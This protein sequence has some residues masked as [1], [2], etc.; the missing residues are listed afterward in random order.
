MPEIMIFKA[1]KYPQGDFDKERMQKMVDAYDPE[2]N[3]EAPVVIGH[4]FF[5][6]SNESQFAHGWVKS[7]RMDGAGKIY[8]DIPEFSVEVK[9][10]IAE[11]KL[12]YI[13]AEIFEFDKIKAGLSPYLRAVA[14][15]GRDT[16]AVP[17]ARL[18]ALFSFIT[19]RDILI[20]EEE[21]TATF[22]RRLGKGEIGKE[23]EEGDMGRVEELEAALKEKEAQIAAFQKEQ[24]KLKNAGRKQE[25]EAYFGKLRDEGKLPPALFERA[26]NLD[27]RLDEESRT[28]FRALVGE[29]GAKVDLSGTHQAKKPQ[30]PS[31]G[32]LT[33]KIRAF[34]KEK[35]FSDFAQAATALQ[36]H[37][38]ELFEAEEGA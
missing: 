10:A 34:Q 38:P 5:S 16:P 3:F 24:E 7:L 30:S 17:A 37:S 6:E 15:L 8:A 23:E 20:N 33:A 36:A 19:G 22:T 31:G 12:R 25:A 1:G 28:E 18:P 9:R 35:N 13:S 26:V 11:N 21:H 27:S 4:R 29:S 2:R 14:L 32:T